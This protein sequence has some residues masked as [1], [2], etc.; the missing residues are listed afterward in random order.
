MSL[1]DYSVDIPAGDRCNTISVSVAHHD[2]GRRFAVRFTCTCDRLV[3]LVMRADESPDHW[4]MWE[5]RR[6]DLPTAEEEIAADRLSFELY[7]DMDQF[8]KAVHHAEAEKRE[9]E[10]QERVQESE[11]A[12]RLLFTPTTICECGRRYRYL[13]N[14]PWIESLRKLAEALEG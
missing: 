5:Y 6:Q 10:L 13:V 2:D 11:A 4:V 7:Q 8:E 12:G 14:K 3:Y 1:L 9:E